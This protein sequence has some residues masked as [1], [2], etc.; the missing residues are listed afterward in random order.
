MLKMEKEYQELYGDIPK[1]S[2]ERLNVL[3]DSFSL[4]R[5]SL[6]I[7]KEIKRITSCGWSEYNYTIY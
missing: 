4:K 1:G 7:F 6:D 2:I 5:Q 3:L